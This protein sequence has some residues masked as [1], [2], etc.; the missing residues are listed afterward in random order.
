MFFLVLINYKGEREA[1]LRAKISIILKTAKY[2]ILLSLC[3]CV[4]IQ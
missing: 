3:S 2:F 4:E 1:N